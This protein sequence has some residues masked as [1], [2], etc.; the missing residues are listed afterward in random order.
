MSSRAAKL[1]SLCNED[2]SNT[3][4][5]NPGDTGND[6]DHDEVSTY[7]IHAP[8]FEIRWQS[9]DKLQAAISGQNLDDPHRVLSTGAILAIGVGVPSALLLLSIALYLIRRR[10]QRSRDSAQITFRAGRQ[11][12]LPE[13]CN[14]PADDVKPLEKK[15]NE[16]G[17]AELEPSEQ[18]AFA[19][20]EPSPLYE[21]E[22][23]SLTDKK[24][25]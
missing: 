11:S 4:Y 18:A 22:D 23:T 7:I 1:V 12:T 17:R 2:S 3:W 20:I 8:M 25:A 15:N 16:L 24:R 5:T 9:A 10:M 21:A 13:V 6:G 14:A 19:L